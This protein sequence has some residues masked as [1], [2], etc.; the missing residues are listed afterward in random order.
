MYTGLPNTYAAPPRRTQAAGASPYTFTN[1]DSVPVR[2][3]VN[4]GTVSL[5]EGQCDGV[6]FDNLGI[7]GGWW[8]LNPGESIRVS[9]AI[10]QP[11]LVICP[12]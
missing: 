4:N 7:T 6:N 2:V 1:N 11:T 9:W 5:I 10:L 12:F 8:L 3:V